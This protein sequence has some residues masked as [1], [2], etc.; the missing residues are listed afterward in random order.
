MISVEGGRYLPFTSQ[1][2]K[3]NAK[4]DAQ[5]AKKPVA[6]A[7]FFLDRTPVTN[8]KFLAF[9]ESHPEWRKSQVR[10]L[11]A[12]AH[13]LQHWKDD[14][15]FPRGHGKQPVT[16][17]SWFA[18]SAY[19]ESL[20]Q[21]LPTTDQWEFALHDSGRDAKQIT[22]K[23]LA[24]YAQPNDTTLKNV[25][26]GK[27]NGY[28]VQ[29][30]TGLVWEWTE[31]FNS[32][33]TNTDSRDNG[34]KEAGLVCGGGSQMGDPSDYAS[35]MRY[36]FRSSLKANYTTANLGFRCA[37]VHDAENKGPRHATK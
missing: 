24:W 19:C 27:A 17:V 10:K 4:K 7:S 35:F 3:P 6:V 30:L 20:G 5:E 26:A 1:A 18:A 29:D 32:F 23:I 34:S 21:R 15:H 36:S 33:L 14:T 16:N 31:D 37:K 9:T 28:G 25:G 22:E 13:Y 8:E 12:D 11:F 2:K